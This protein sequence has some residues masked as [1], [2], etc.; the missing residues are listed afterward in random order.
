MG[1]RVG[2]Q[3]VG[4]RAPSRGIVVIAIVPSVGGNEQRQFRWIS[5]PPV[6]SSTVQADIIQADIIGVRWNSDSGFTSNIGFRIKIETAG[7]QPQ[8]QSSVTL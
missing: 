4:A 5:N 8:A 2:Q 1:K 6:G 3:A 7:F